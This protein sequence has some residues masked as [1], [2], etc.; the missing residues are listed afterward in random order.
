[1]CLRWYVSKYLLV[2]ISKPIEYQIT[3]LSLIL[4]NEY[5]LCLFFLEEHSHYQKGTYKTKKI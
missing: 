2:L 1:M 3:Y 4:R 5:H